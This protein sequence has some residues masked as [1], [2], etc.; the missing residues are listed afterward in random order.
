MGSADMRLLRQ[1]SG[2]GLCVFLALSAGRAAVALTNGAPSVIEKGATLAEVVN[3]LGKPQGLL[4]QGTNVTLYY[5]CGLIDLSDGKVVTAYLVSP[6]EAALLRQTRERELEEL[7][8][9]AENN[10]KRLTSEGQAALKKTLDD[11]QF[12]KRPPRERVAYWQ[13][14]QQRYHFTDIGSRLADAMKEAAYQ[15]Q[16]QDNQDEIAQLKIRV[17]AINDRLLQLDADYAASLTHWKRN[18]INAERAKLNQELDDINRRIKELN[19]R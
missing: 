3:V 1:R 11:K 14:F 9:Q 15:Q 18:E 8:R 5:D 6:A 16:Q 19:I 4:E 12:E 7:R 17:T 13:D 2:F 10:R